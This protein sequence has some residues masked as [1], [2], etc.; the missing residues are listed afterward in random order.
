MR[1]SEFYIEHLHMTSYHAMAAI[2]V[3]NEN[4]LRLCTEMAA[5]FMAK[6]CIQGCIQKFCQRGG[7]GG[8]L[9]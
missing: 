5:I 1:C 3:H 8:D 9:Q 7:G 6:G 4:L 2:L